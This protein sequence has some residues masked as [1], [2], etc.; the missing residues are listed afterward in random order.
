[1]GGGFFDSTGKHCAHLLAILTPTSH[2]SGLWEISPIFAIRPHLCADSRR[3][4]GILLSRSG[5]QPTALPGLASCDLKL[6]L[7]H[8]SQWTATHFCPSQRHLLSAASYWLFDLLHLAFLT[9]WLRS[10]LEVS[11]EVPAAS[12]EIPR[13]SSSD[14]SG[15]RSATLSP[16]AHHHLRPPRTQAASMARL[17]R[18]RRPRGF[19][20][21]MRVK[22]SSIQTM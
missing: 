18:Q 15:L 6:S 19:T 17:S 10:E 9:C 5:G 21:V 1:M 11:L 3:V 2:T 20:E 22:M 7:P 13:W 14:P 8:F 12:V 4:H 16:R